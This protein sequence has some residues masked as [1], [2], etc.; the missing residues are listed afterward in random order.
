MSD[1]SIAW[2]MKEVFGGALPI[3]LAL[4]DAQHTGNK[5]SR[6]LRGSKGQ[7]VFMVHVLHHIGN[8]E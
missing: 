7:T 2:W 6:L 4:V 8:G 1:A 3:A 5:R